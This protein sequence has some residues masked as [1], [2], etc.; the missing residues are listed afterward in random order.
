MLL[1]PG[2][3]DMREE[4]WIE[5]CFRELPDRDY[6]ELR[7]RLLELEGIHGETIREQ[8]PPEDPAIINEMVSERLRYPNVS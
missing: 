4:S 2:A 3:V 8:F 6:N 1:S 5:E 7:D